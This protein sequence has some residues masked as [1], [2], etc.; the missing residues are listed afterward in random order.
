MKSSKDRGFTLLELLVVVLVIVLVLAVTIPSMSR[1]SASVSLRTTSRDVLNIFRYARE[2]AV[3]EQVGMKVTADRENQRLIVADD[4][5]IGPPAYLMP[6]DVKIER[7]VLGGKNITDGPVVLRFLP[8]GSSDLGEVVLKSKAG[9]FLRI[10]SDPLAGGAR[11][12]KGEGEN[13]P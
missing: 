9:S 3:T 6:T 11:I 1:S 12:E 8:N 5:G 4:F 7:I 13:L 2:K 10:I